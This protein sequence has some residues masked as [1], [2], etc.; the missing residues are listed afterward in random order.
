MVI[1]E[2]CLTAVNAV[3]G[4]AHCALADLAL[5][6]AATSPGNAALVVNAD[7]SFLKAFGSFQKFQASCPIRVLA[8]EQNGAG[9]CPLGKTAGLK[10]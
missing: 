7:I 5:V 10:S 9:V 3:H 1:R 2:D 6:A 4:G 8:L